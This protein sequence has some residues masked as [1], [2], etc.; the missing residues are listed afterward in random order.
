MKYSKTTALLLLSAATLAACD[1][2]TKQQLA[3]VTHVDSMRVDSLSNVRRDLLDEV[4]TS[5][6]FVNQINTELM[7]ARVLASQKAVQLD[8][9]TEGSKVNEERR[10]VVARITHLVA[11]LDSVQNRLDRTRR[12]ARAMTKQDSTLLTQVAEYEKTISDLQATAEKQRADFQ[13]ALDTKTKEVAT[14]NGEVDTLTQVRNTLDDQVHTLTAEKNTAYYVIGTKDELI[15]K[16]IL[17]EEG[18][19]SFLLVGSRPVSP[20]RQL[21]PS[22]F[23]KINRLT[24]RTIQLPQGTYQIVS[25]QNPA[26]TETEKR[27]DGKLSGSLTIDQPE[28]FWAPSAYLIIVRS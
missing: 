24:D 14:L 21:D 18:H 23:T 9:N 5:T 11:R 4:M 1:N 25:R 6:Q 27:P 10:A 2:G 7:K 17:V 28:Q 22:A 19:K 15:K 8:E 20:A 3:T 13:T 26:F 16:G 12:E